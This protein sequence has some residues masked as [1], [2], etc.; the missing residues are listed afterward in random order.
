MTLN[1]ELKKLYWYPTNYKMDDLSKWSRE[2]VDLL[3]T[4]KPTY[5]KSDLVKIGLIAK[6][7]SAAK[8]DFKEEKRQYT[9]NLEEGEYINFNHK[10]LA[11]GRFEI[12]GVTLTKELVDC[13]FDYDYY[14][15]FCE[16]KEDLKLVF[17]TKAQVVNRQ[18]L[19]ELLEEIKKL[20]QARVKRDFD[21]IKNLK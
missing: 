12:N 4:N 17:N 15:D 9:Y 7:T 8:L 14:D 18:Q 10:F 5:T 6:R 20:Y 13:Y 16:A 11:S 19:Y 21:H 2:L 3:N 1:F